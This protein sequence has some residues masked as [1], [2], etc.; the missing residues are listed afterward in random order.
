MAITLFRDEK[1]EFVGML[2]F[3]MEI[4]ER[5]QAEK[6]LRENGDD[7]RMRVRELNCLCSIT[8]VVNKYHDSLE[9]LLQETWAMPAC[10]TH[11]AY[12]SCTR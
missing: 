2:A 8:E 12:V 3:V 5:K 10:G 9:S 1:G 11:I 7:L 6:M 4:T